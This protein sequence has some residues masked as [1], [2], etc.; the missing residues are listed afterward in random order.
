MTR[1]LLLLFLLPVFTHT[2][3]LQTFLKPNDSILTAES[4]QFNSY[5]FFSI[6]TPGDEYKSRNSMTCEYSNVLDINIRQLLFDLCDTIP[7]TADVAQRLADDIQKG[8]FTTTILKTVSG[9]SLSIHQYKSPMYPPEVLLNVCLENNVNINECFTEHDSVLV[10]NFNLVIA[11]YT[12]PGRCVSMRDVR[13]KMESTLDGMYALVFF[14]VIVGLAFTAF[15]VFIGYK[16]Y[17]RRKH[18]YLLIDRARN[19]Q[20]T[21]PQKQEV[22]T[23]EYFGWNIPTEDLEDSELGKAIPKIY[24]P[25]PLKPHSLVSN[26]SIETPDFPTEPRDSIDE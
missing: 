3:A 11:D 13:Q 23:Q 6:T 24:S 20:E 10:Q 4:P 14:N 12:P 1:V 9:V 7:V 19:L 22:V 15:I 26:N 16:L 2:V 18:H 5:H 21:D 8:T 25:K 17:Q